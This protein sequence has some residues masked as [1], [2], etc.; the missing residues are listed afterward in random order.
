[1]LCLVVLGCD[2]YSSLKGKVL[3]EAGEPVGDAGVKVEVDNRPARRELRTE[4]DGAFEFF[5]NVNPMGDSK[6]EVT[7]SKGGYETLTQKFYS[8]DLP[9][10]KVNEKEPE[11]RVFV[12]R[13]SAEQP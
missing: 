4:N 6:I 8:S 2:K 9:V 12:L 11:P 10:P 5:D 3:D 1:M 13:R 7:I